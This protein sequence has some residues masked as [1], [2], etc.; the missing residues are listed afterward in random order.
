MTYALLLGLALSSG[1]G[2]RPVG[3]T[4]DLILRTHA[5]EVRTSVDVT[6]KRDSGRGWNLRQDVVVGS[7]W[8]GGVRYQTWSG[9]PWRKQ[10][11]AV[12]AGVNVGQ[13]RVLASRTLA[14][15]YGESSSSLT[16]EGGGRLRLSVGVVRFTQQRARW[17][18]VA[19]ATV[20]VQ[21]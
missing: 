10:S 13:L 15:S 9:G 21:R 14:S 3:P 4:A 17:G 12:L 18:V 1:L 8:L 7:R 11:M 19:G 16:L 2:Y 20:G 5:L 6:P